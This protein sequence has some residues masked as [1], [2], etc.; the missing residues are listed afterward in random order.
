VRAT[1]RDRVDLGFRLEHSQP[2]GR[3]K[4]SRIHETMPLQVSLTKVNDLDQEVRKWLRK[5]YEENR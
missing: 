5:A 2:R 3:L 4:P 1:T